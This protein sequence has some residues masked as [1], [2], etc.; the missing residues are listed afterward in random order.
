MTTMADEHPRG[1]L[2]YSAHCVYNPSF[3]NFS[4]FFSSGLK[5][6][7][8]RLFP[9]P[10]NKSPHTEVN[11]IN[12]YVSGV[13]AGALLK[14]IFQ[15]VFLLWLQ[16]QGSP[17]VRTSP[18]GN[19]SLCRDGAGLKKGKPGLGRGRPGGVTI[20]GVSLAGGDRPGAEHQRQDLSECLPQE[21]QLLP[22]FLASR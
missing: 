3:S 21:T 13:R 20:S 7:A 2:L 14:L 6:R 4:Y 18:S 5:T 8:E 1:I 15:N 19:Q 11:N 9:H 10:L 22:T 17:P 16:L 12:T